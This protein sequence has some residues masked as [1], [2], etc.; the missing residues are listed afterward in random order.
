[1]DASSPQQKRLAT[2]ALQAVE[3]TKETDTMFLAL[4]TFEEVQES[5]AMD[6]EADLSALKEGSC[7][8]S[9]PR[10]Y[11]GHAQQLQERQVHCD[12]GATLD[13]S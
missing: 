4:Y 1:M 12:S 13:L 10:S 3:P 11:C 6:G 7:K 2:E 9:L 8:A 5:W